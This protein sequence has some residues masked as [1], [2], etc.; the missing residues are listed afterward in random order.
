M[1][2]FY[3]TLW[4]LTFM[5]I[6]NWAFLIRMTKAFQKRT[7]SWLAI[8]IAI[9]NR[10]RTWVSRKVGKVTLWISI[11]KRLRVALNFIIRIKDKPLIQ[12]VWFFR[13]LVGDFVFN[14]L[15][16]KLRMIRFLRYILLPRV[17]H[18][19]FQINIINSFFIKSKNYI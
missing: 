11:S 9:L 6:I 7:L 2:Q 15:K 17:W 19:R 4:T 3:P 18:P 12:N 13:L 1:Q 10:R 8:H 14:G 16:L 5:N